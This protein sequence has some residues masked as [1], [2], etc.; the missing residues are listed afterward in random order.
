[1]LVQ[2]SEN[3]GMLR[4]EAGA[5]V[6][7]DANGSGG[8]ARGQGDKGTREG[9][10]LDSCATGFVQSS[11]T[12]ACSICLPFQT[13]ERPAQVSSPIP[14]PQTGMASLLGQEAHGCVQVRCEL[15]QGGEP[16][17]S[18]CGTMIIVKVFCVLRPPASTGLTTV[19]SVL[20]WDP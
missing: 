5:E 12:P 14:A 1:M 3:A 18:P 15:S 4:N 19:S 6:S 10:W 8:P 20:F 11:T 9:G 16:T 17:G 13:T 2:E 7:R